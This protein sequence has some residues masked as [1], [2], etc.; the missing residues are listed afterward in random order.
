MTLTLIILA[1][2]LQVLL[3]RYM[4]RK[5]KGIISAIVWF[6]PVMQTGIIIGLLFWWIWELCDNISLRKPIKWFFNKDLED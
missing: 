4:D 3:C 5:N 1:Y 6:I 2:I